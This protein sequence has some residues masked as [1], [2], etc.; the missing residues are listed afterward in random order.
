AQQILL[1]IPPNSDDATKKQIAARADS[2]Y[3]RIVAGENFNRLDAAFSND[4]ISAANGGTM[5][6]IGVG[7][8]DPVFE[9]VLWSLPKDGAMSKPFLTTHGWHIVKRTSMKP[10]ITDSANRSNN[11]DL[12]QKVMA[13]P[14]WKSSKDFIYRT[15]KEKTGFKKYPYNDETIWA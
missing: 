7:Q 5:P 12:Q 10:V 11:A 14:R 4:Y 8:Y 3:K 6:D 15:V 1:A 9:T 13:D 2:L